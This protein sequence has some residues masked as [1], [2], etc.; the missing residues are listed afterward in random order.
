MSEMNGKRAA[1]I[2]NGEEIPVE[3]QGY[4]H[5]VCADGGYNALRALGVVPDAIVGDMDSIIPEYLEDARSKGVLLIRYDADKNET[6]GALAL[7]YLAES[8]AAAVDI[9]GAFGGRQDHQAENLSLLRVARKSGIP[10]KICGA[11]FDVYFVSGR[12]AAF[13]IRDVFP[14]STVSV[15]PVTAMRFEGSRGLK[16]ALSNLLIQPGS[17]RGISNL[18]TADSFDFTLRSGSGYVYVFNRANA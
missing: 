7:K 4:S 10:A 8:G 12:N 16:Y 9:Y 1:L 17:G 5:I 14:G 3:I 6:D 15:A 11:G 2:L 18:T 13:E